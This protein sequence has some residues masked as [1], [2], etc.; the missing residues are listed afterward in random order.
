M[1]AT[2]VAETEC[3]RHLK[4][5]PISFHDVFRSLNGINAKVPSRY[6][7]EQTIMLFQLIYQKHAVK[8]MKGLK[9]QIKLKEALILIRESFEN[10]EYNNINYNVWLEYE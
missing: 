2:H 10:G 9:I 7:F 4:I 8:I 1:K 6:G 3:I 5:G